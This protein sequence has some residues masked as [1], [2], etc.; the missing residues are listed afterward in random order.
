[1]STYGK[2]RKWGSLVLLL[3]LTLCFILLFTLLTFFNPFERE[4]NEIAR[5]SSLVLNTRILADG[6]SVFSGITSSAVIYGDDITE[7][8]QIAYVPENILSRLD[9]ILIQPTVGSFTLYADDEKLMSFPSDGGYIDLGGRTFFTCKAGDLGGKEIR[10]VTNTGGIRPAVG[11]RVYPIV[12]TTDFGINS[13]LSSYLLPAGFFNGASLVLLLVLVFIFVSVKSAKARNTV[14]AFLLIALLNGISSISLY[15]A[16]MILFNAPLFWDTVNNFV[17]AAIVLCFVSFVM[18][19]TDRSVMKSKTSYVLSLGCII[20]FC[21]HTVL[22]F[23]GLRLSF[24]IGRLLMAYRIITLLYI[25]ITVCSY[26]AKNRRNSYIVASTFLFLLSVIINTVLSVFMAPGIWQANAVSFLRLASVLIIVFRNAA[27]H[28]SEEMNLIRETELERN[29]LLDPLSG[30]FSRRKYE[31][32]LRKPD[33]L[34]GKHICIVFID[35]NSLKRINDCFGHQEGDKLIKYCGRTLLSFF[36]EDAG[37]FRIGGDE[38]CCLVSTEGRPQLSM[39][40]RDLKER[41]SS[42]SPYG[43]TISAGGLSIVVGEESDLRD[44]VSK[45]D[46]LMYRDKRNSSASA[47]VFLRSRMVSDGY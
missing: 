6:N 20:L 15:P 3:S 5:T 31:E 26:W 37:I 28:V 43:A 1:M 12:I 21:L 18:T 32:L 47:S 9:T 29:A 16:G 2:E 46:E 4:V 25:L 36:G 11:F 17:N 13:M 8:T 7:V 10:V 45:A 39:M 23:A 41:F 35:I 44:A 22:S 40:I 27:G 34:K 38:F 19:V 42:S 24:Y 30:C 14:A 33:D